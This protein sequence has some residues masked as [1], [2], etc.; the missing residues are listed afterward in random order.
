MSIVDDIF[1]RVLFDEK[2]VCLY[3]VIYD[4]VKQVGNMMD[5]NVPNCAEK[6]LAIRAL[7]LACMHFGSA[8]GKQDKYKSS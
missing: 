7:H 5:D 6:T 3:Q 1:H 8:L 4:A 2:D